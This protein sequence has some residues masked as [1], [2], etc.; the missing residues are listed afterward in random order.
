MET[1]GFRF[2]VDTASILGSISLVVSVLLLFRELRVNNRLT[3]A[4]NTQA[5][6]SLSSPFYMGVIQDRTLAQLYARGGQD[7][8]SMDEVD[9]YRYNSLLVWWLIFHENVFY[10]WRQR[11]LDESSYKPW[12]REL[13]LFVRR[14]NLVNSWPLLRDLFQ[15][16]FAQ[17]VDRLIV[18][19]RDRELLVPGGP[20][21]APTPSRV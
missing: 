5:L 1:A 12:V 15:D 13:E 19:R 3:R 18:E 10:Q 9:R 6:V 2:L 21:C 17:H 11:L 14:H 8:E 20:P 7:V 4:G 16:E